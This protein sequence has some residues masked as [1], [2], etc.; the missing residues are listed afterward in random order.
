MKD[1]AVTTTA[2]ADN[3]ATLDVSGLTDAAIK[4]ATG[5]TRLV[6]LLP[7]TGGAVRIVDECN[8]KYCYCGGFSDLMPPKWRYEVN[9][10]TDGTVTRW[11]AQLKPQCTAG[12]TTKT[13]Y[14]VEQLHR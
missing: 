2:Y 11:L 4:T 14:G 9:V 10:A 6:R 1:T 5:G 13:E 3:G 7:A 8:N 12:V